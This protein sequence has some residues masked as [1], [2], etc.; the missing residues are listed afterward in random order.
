[1]FKGVQASSEN[2]KDINLDRN[3]NFVILHARVHHSMLS[4][5]YVETSDI[6]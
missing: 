6:F 2:N 5:L 1:M 4:R 3:A